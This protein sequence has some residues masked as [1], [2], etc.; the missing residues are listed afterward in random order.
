MRMPEQRQLHPDQRSRSPSCPR[1]IGTAAASH[2]NKS[3]S[4]DT[5]RMAPTGTTERLTCTMLIH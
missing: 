4:G 5:E 2:P 1:L 3:V